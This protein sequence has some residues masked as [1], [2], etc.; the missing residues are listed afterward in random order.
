MNA[1]D[2]S[3]IALL[4]TPSVVVGVVG[5]LLKRAINGTDSAVHALQGEVKSFG[6]AMQ[7]RDLLAARSEARL[8]ARIE[9]LERELFNPKKGT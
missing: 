4:V 2:V 1:P 9:A 8:E 5:W 6:A 7:A 3:L